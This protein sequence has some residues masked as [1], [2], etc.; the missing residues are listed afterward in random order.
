MV[1]KARAVKAAVDDRSYLSSVCTFSF[2]SC[3]L[4]RTYFNLLECVIYL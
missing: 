3:V 2:S 1:K 4:A